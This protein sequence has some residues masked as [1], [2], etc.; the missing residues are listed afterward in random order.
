[1]IVLSSEDVLLEW[2]EVGE[3]LERIL[4]ALTKNSVQAS[5]FNMPIELP[6]TRLSLRQM[7]GIKSWPQLLLRIG[8][9]LEEPATSPR[10]AVEECIIPFAG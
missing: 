10:R 5:F 4:L 1:L 6:D 3:L 2:L 9:S 7:L 8:Y